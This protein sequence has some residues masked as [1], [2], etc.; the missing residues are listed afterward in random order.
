MT[1][2]FPRQK[3][4]PEPDRYLCWTHCFVVYYTNNRDQIGPSHFIY[5]STS[6]RIGS[7]LTTRRHL[8]ERRSYNNWPDKIR[9]VKRGIVFPNFIFL[10]TSKLKSRATPHNFVLS[11]HDSRFYHAPGS[12]CPGYRF[13]S[14]QVCIFFLSF[15]F[16]CAMTNG[17]M[18]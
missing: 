18:G 4:R 5:W 2:L 10:R 12:D 6:S 14:C 7:V 9:F 15:L 1:P 13:P 8:R 16:D 3:S 17:P 11:E